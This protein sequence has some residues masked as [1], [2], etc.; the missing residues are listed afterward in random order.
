M[1]LSE[2][3]IYN[4]A[5]DI[6]DEIWN[7]VDSWDY[8]QKDT[9]GKQLVRSADSISANIAEGY[10]RFYYKLKRIYKGHRQINIFNNI[11]LISQNK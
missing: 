3:R 6:G 11:N 9:L 5:N 7:I 4:L 10:G 8:F 1:I 2:L